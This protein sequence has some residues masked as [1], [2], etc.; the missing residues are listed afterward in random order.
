MPAGRGGEVC[1]TV[2]YCASVEFSRSAGARG[3]GFRWM[4]TLGGYMP[5][6]RGGNLAEPFSFALP[7]MNIQGARRQGGAGFGGS[8]H[9]A[10]ALLVYACKLCREDERTDCFFIHLRIL[11]FPGRGV[12]FSGDLYNRRRRF[13]WIHAFGTGGEA[14]CTVPF[15]TSAD[16]FSRNGGT[17]GSGFRWITILGGSYQRDE[18][19]NFLNFF[20]F[21]F[22]R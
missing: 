15:C 8:I 14:R 20:L 19:E 17:R 21:R 2:S 11:V 12:V 4:A 6:G 22:R 7:P 18:R 9:S 1:C 3:S 13:W 16:E 10:A 5:E